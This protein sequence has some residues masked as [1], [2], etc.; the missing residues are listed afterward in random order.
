MTKHFFNS[1][2]LPPPFIILSHLLLLIQAFSQRF[3]GAKREGR[4]HE[5]EK[6]L[7]SMKMEE[8]CSYNYI[9]RKRYEKTDNSNDRILALLKDIEKSIKD[10]EEIN[11]DE[12]IFSS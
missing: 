3:K 11:K 4:S 1:P 8:L 10:G 7:E 12:M 5:K 9:K 6:R 2:K